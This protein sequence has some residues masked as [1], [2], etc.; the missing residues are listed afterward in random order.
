MKKRI[1][2]GILM[3]MMF[4]LSTCLVL[5]GKPPKTALDVTISNPDDG[6]EVSYDEVDE[7]CGTFEVTGTVTAKRGDA[8]LVQT[9]VQYAIGEGSTDFN[10]VGD[11]QIQIVSGDEHQ[12]A[13][14]GKDQWYDVNW[15]LTGVPDTYEIRL[16]SEGAASKDGESSSRTVTLLG[17]PPEPPPEPPT[18]C[19][20]IDD[21]Y[22]DPENSF[23]TSSGTFVDTYFVD[24]VYEVLM[25]QP[26]SHGTKN[27][28]DDTADLNWIYEFDDL[29][30]RTNTTFRFVGHIELSGEYLDSGFLEWDDQ[31]TAFYV[32]AMS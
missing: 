27:P 7:A 25:E 20:T 32:Q 22:V 26:N 18:D 16:F 15:T 11:A 24:E 21:E 1:L 4:S 9:S 17:A 5:A 8:G 6:L 12:D 31:D 19:E 10:F 2:I 23:G 3:V 28:T 13:I 29:G 14:L 30:T